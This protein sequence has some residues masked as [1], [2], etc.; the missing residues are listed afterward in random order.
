MDWDRL[1]DIA[2]GH[3][4]YTVY[5]EVGD[6]IWGWSWHGVE[7]NYK[8]IERGYENDGD[9]LFVEIPYTV[10]G[11]YSGGSVEHANTEWFRKENEGDENVVIGWGGHYSEC[12]L[13]R[14]DNLDE[15]GWDDLDC[16]FDTLAN[17]PVIDDEA[18][19]DYE[20]ELT[21]E[22]LDEYVS[23][24]ARHSDSLEHTSE[25][26]IRALFWEGLY[27]D[28]AYEVIVEEA[29]QCYL[30]EDKVTEYVVKGLGVREVVTE[31]LEL[32]ELLP[33]FTRL[34][35]DS[36]RKTIDLVFH[37]DTDFE[38]VRVFDTIE[39]MKAY[40]GGS[41]ERE[42]AAAKNLSKGT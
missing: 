31:T 32:W 19:S 39:E 12:V 35:V 1:D 26:A 42:R 25:V 28:Q 4:D 22:W 36:G 27:Q 11:D 18:L 38:R 33:A 23:Y 24:S 29:H 2:V 37:P 16:L 34:V 14:V 13:M 5:V 6:G 9:K 40:L 8:V 3:I 20:H 10:H 41:D 17:Y 7:H 15:E 21:E 30:D